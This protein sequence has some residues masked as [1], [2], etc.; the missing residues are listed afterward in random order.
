MVSCTFTTLKITNLLIYFNCS[1]KEDFVFHCLL[2]LFAF[3]TAKVPENHFLNTKIFLLIKVAMSHSTWTM[4]HLQT[5]IILM[6]P[7]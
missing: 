3:F 7:T 2:I 4:D 6:P 1:K 5:A